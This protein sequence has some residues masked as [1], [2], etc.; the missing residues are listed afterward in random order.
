MLNALPD[1]FQSRHFQPGPRGGSWIS[2]ANH[3]RLL[4]YH[5]GVIMWEQES[6]SNIFNGCPISAD[7]APIIRADMQRTP[8][9]PRPRPSQPTLDAAY[10]CLCRYVSAYAVPP[11]PPLPACRS[12]AGRL[13]PRR[14]HGRI[15]NAPPPPTPAR[16]PAAAPP[17]AASAV[18]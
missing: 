6:Q 13:L 12:R 15:R 8:P 3:L 2:R 11:P 16:R 14:P 18:M 10:C 7:R 4:T 5:M 1:Q 9:L 17:T